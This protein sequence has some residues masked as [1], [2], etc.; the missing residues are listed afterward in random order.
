MIKLMNEPLNIWIDASMNR[1]K[2]LETNKKPN[3]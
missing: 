2:N 1:F 3:E